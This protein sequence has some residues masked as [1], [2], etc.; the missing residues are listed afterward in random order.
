MNTKITLGGLNRDPK[1]EQKKKKFDDAL[2]NLGV[3]QKDNR[4]KKN[5]EKKEMAKLEN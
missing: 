5:N 3:V 1:K 2:L 4:T